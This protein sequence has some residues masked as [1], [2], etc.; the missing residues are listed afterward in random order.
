MKT[1]P[2]HYVPG[3][4]HFS[5]VER[6]HFLHFAVGR[7]RHEFR[8]SGSRTEQQVAVDNV[9][10]K[11]MIEH[12]KCADGF[13]LTGGSWRTDIRVPVES[14]RIN[15]LDIPMEDFERYLQREGVSGG[16]QYKI[17]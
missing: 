10:E 7:L 9:T 11:N 1:V 6:K 2:A 17:T 8:Q 14:E 3:K 5:D 15:R 16:K 4:I 13:E 12:I